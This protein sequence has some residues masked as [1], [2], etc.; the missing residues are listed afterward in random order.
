[1]IVKQTQGWEQVSRFNHTSKYQKGCG[2][3]SNFT[4]N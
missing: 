1:M 2:E 4:Q 3:Q